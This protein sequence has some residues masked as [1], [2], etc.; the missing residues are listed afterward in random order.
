MTF[1]VRLACDFANSILSGKQSSVDCRPSE[2]KIYSLYLFDL[3]NFEPPFLPMNFQESFLIGR[4]GLKTKLLTK[5]YTHSF[6]GSG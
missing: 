2:I 6:N 5:F 3:S 4:L 1:P